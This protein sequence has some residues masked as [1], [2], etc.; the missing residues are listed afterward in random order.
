MIPAIL[1]AIEALGAS[2]GGAATGAGQA[3]VGGSTLAGMAGMTNLAG[4]LKTLG[5]AGQAVGQVFRGITGVFSSLKSIAGI[6]PNLALGAFQKLID[7]G[8]TVVDVVHT[9]ADIVKLAN[10]AQ[11]KVFTWA[12]QDMIAVFGHYLVPVLQQITSIVREVG[13]EFAS[14]NGLREL[15]KS[16]GEAMGRLWAVF[17]P[18]VKNAIRNV[19]VLANTIATFMKV[20]ENNPLGGVLPT[21]TD[22]FLQLNDALRKLPLALALAVE[23]VS[24]FANPKNVAKAIAGQ[25]ESPMDFVVRR[26]AEMN[27]RGS[28]AGAA[29]GNASFSSFEEVGKK[30]QQ[31]AFALSMAGIQ[32]PEAKAE[33]QRD[34]QIDRLE[35]VAATA[36]LIAQGI[37]AGTARLVHGF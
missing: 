18:L 8:G 32:S 13:D 17:G 34:K 15:F 21:I 9:I 30:A 36:A 19:D 24:H 3:A 11:F 1:G 35:Q 6:G 10:P 12:W 7:V 14:M 20:F 2:A 4:T 33:E 26:W 28:A 27:K 25:G 16:L 31:Q 22:L 5:T 29:A 23:A 37:T